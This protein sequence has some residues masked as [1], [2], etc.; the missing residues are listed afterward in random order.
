MVSRAGVNRTE[1]SSDPGV[2]VVDY[3][4]KVFVPGITGKLACS[5]V[6][7]YKDSWR[8]HIKSR[9]HGRVR[10]FRTVDGE[11]LM[12]EIETANKTNLAHNTYW[13]IKVT[14]S[15]MFTF[16][17]R[18]GIFDGVNP[19]CGVSI[20]KGRKHGRKRLAYSLL[21]VEAQ[22]QAFDDEPTVLAIIGTAALAGLRQGEIR[23]L[24]VD[25]DEG[26]VRK[27]RR[28]VWRTIVKDTKTEEDEEDPGAV[29]IIRPFVFFSIGSSQQ[30]AG[31]SPT[32]LAVPSIYITSPSV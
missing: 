4:E 11:N 28:S 1:K 16:A 21:E 5:T 30:A 29:P 19:M 20:P 31:Y 26:D 17:K 15:A 2:K 23:G 10:D 27:I 9:I 13:H 22:L 3:F 6:K 25:D 18:K 12:T 24:W 8:C 32:K 7:G 14:L